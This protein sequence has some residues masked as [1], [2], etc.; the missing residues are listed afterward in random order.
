MP[1]ETLSQA[2]PQ[3]QAVG[4][5]HLTFTLGQE[6]YGLP[7][8]MVREIIGLMEIT[9]VPRMPG[10]VRGVINLRGK[11]IPVVDLRMKFGFERIEDTKL[12][13]II[14]VDLHTFLMGVVVDMVNEVVDVAPGDVEDTPTFGANIST[15]FIRAMG[16][17][18]GKVLILLDIERVLSAGEQLALS[19]L[20]N[21]QALAAKET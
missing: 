16:K 9:R 20:A 5:K 19:P 10:F 14:V 21:E 17:V 4:G 8:L 12:T 18:K 1:A 7:V 3:T 13:C 2:T 11:V 15:E 6:T